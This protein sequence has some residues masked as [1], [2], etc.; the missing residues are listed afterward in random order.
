MPEVAAVR[1]GEELPLETLAEWLGPRLAG[2]S[3]LEIRQFPSGHSNLTYLLRTRT[4]PGEYV[5]RRP[6]LGPVAA[7]AHDM[8]REHRVLQAVH[9]HYPPAPRPILACDDA[10]VIGAPFFVMERRNGVVPRYGVPPEY[11]GNAEA[12]GRMSQALIDGL[13]RLHRIDVQATGTVALGKPDGFLER[14]VSGWTSRWQAALTEPVPAMEPVLS[15]LATELPP[16]PYTTL[17]HQDYKLDNTLFDPADPGRLTAVLDWE[18]ATVGDPLA[19]LGLSLTY[20]SIPEARGVAGMDASA[21]W[22][23]R[24]QMMQRYQE[25]TGFELGRLNWY[26]VFG[27]FKLAVIVQQIYARYVR[28]QTGDSRFSRMG[29]MAV[30]LARRA[31]SMIQ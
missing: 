26:E 18:M 5:L 7:K 23:S 29:E 31:R 6:P 3:D 14:Q 2:G 11:A 15:W 22:W 17:V 30:A 25:L 21:G 16:S 19:D 8:L 24:E 10:G 13:A 9:P 28:G 1:A 4:P 27:T 20:W 12:P